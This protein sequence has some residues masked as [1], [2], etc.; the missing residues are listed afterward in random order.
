MSDYPL[1]TEER[2]ESIS[3]SID[4]ISATFDRINEK[5]RKFDAFIEKCW[6]FIKVP[7]FCLITIAVVSTIIEYVIK[8]R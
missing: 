2:M 7:Y 6:N 3:R 8:S 4:E 5:N 1:T